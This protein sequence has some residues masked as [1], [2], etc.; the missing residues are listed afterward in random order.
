VDIFVDIDGTIAKTK[1]T[2][3]MHSQPISKVI[4]EIN[5]CY[6]QGDKIIYWTARGTKTGMD[7]RQLTEN[8]LKAWGCKYTE[9]RFG[10]PVMGLYIGNEA[11]SVDEWM[12]SKNDSTTK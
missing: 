2:D 6:E 3:Y 1:G 8:Q 7:W 5:K 10:K 11:V 12:R 4:L 9:L